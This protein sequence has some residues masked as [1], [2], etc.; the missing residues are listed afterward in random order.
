MSLP[1]LSKAPANL[2]LSKT[3]N[4]N[5]EGRLNSLSHDIPDRSL[6]EP[7][8]M[9]PEMTILDRNRE[10]EKLVNSGVEQIP[11]TLMLKLPK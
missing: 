10:I 8:T 1:P 9:I 4:S 6:G 11:D 2:P 5:Y 7:Y 3:P